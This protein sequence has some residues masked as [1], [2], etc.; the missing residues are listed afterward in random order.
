MINLAFAVQMA[1]FLKAQQPMYPRGP[2]PP[3]IGRVQR[4]ANGIAAFRKQAAMQAAFDAA[5]NAPA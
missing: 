4:K 1:L 5:G 3:N 2:T